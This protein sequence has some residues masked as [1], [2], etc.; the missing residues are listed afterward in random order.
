MSA[1][2]H[3]LSTANDIW[4]ALNTHETQDYESAFIYVNSYNGQKEK[5]NNKVVRAI[6]IDSGSGYLTMKGEYFLLE[7]HI[8][9]PTYDWKWVY[10]AKIRHSL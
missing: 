9:N 8:Y 4:N 7:G 5:Y 6:S 3:Y 10:R 1:M 2:V